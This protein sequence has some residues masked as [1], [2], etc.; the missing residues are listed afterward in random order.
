MLLLAPQSGKRTRAKI[1]LK[2]IELRDQT[3]EA[4]EDVVAQ[5]RVKARQ[6]TAG[7][8]E[9]AE[10]LQHRGQE[11][12]DEQVARVSAVVEAGKTAVQGS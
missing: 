11:M 7:V 5:A 3:A 2:G 1:Q 6:V 9:K 12:L 4:V 10:E 8:R